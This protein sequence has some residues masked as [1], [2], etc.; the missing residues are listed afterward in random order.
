L[1]PVFAVLEQQQYLLYTKGLG[2][3]ADRRSVP[4]KHAHIFSGT[5]NALSLPLWSFFQRK[6][7]GATKNSARE[8][9]SAT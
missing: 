2:S 5:L 7:R 6:F 4:Q 1:W 3:G 9:L 8:S